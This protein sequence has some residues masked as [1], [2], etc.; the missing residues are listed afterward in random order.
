MLA[1]LFFHRPS[2]DV[3]TAEYEQGMRDFHAA[4]AEVGVAGFDGSRTYR[5][6]GEYCDW[7]LVETSAALDVLNEAAVSGARS[8]P[9][10]A[11]ARHATDF[12]GKLM[13]L[14]AGIY[15]ADARHEIRFSKPRGMTYPD[16]YGQLKRWTDR[17]DVSLWRRMMVLG[18][19]PEFCLVARSEVELPTELEPQ[20]L[21]RDPV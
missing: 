9:H 15:H 16:L 11:V 4:L 10:D 6:G 13:K 17:P 8:S 18:P 12:R 14:V 1:Y 3:D 2:A 20:G 5:V 21:I 7:Y 19:A